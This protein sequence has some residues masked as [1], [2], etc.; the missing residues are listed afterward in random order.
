MNHKLL[1]RIATK[2]AT[3]RTN[4]SASA[5]AA[6]P[7][8]SRIVN[9]PSVINSLQRFEAIVNFTTSP[10]PVNFTGFDT[11]ANYANCQLDGFYSAAAVFPPDQ[12]YPYITLRC[13]LSPKT[14][15][16]KPLYISLNNQPGFNVPQQLNFQAPPS[17]VN[18]SAPASPD[19]NLWYPYIGYALNN[20]VAPRVPI[21]LPYTASY[22]FQYRTDPESMGGFLGALTPVGPG[23]VS[24]SIAGNTTFA[25]NFTGNDPS[26]LTFDFTASA[27]RPGCVITP[28]NV[29]FQTTRPGAIPVYVFTAQLNSGPR[30]LS[31]YVIAKNG[32]VARKY[33]LTVTTAVLAV[34][35]ALTIAASTATASVPAPTM[36][37]AFS[38]T[39][40][41]YSVT[42]DT[43]IA[44]VSF[45]A[46]PN[47]QNDQPSINWAN[48]AVDTSTT[49]QPPYPTTQTS[50]VQLQAPQGYTPP[51]MCRNVS[52]SAPQ[53]TLGVGTYNRLWYPSGATTFSGSYQYM[54]S[55]PTAFTCVGTTTFYVFVAIPNNDTVV[56]YSIRIT[57]KPATTVPAVDPAAIKVVY[58]GGGLSVSTVFSN[59]QNRVTGF[60]ITGTSIF[61]PIILTVQPTIPTYTIQV[62]PNPLVLNAL[63]SPMT[64][65][66]VLVSWD[67]VTTTTYDFYVYMRSG[68]LAGLFVG[69]WAATLGN[70][71]LKNWPFTPAFEGFTQ[72]GYVATVSD[73]SPYVILTLFP[74]SP[75]ANLTVSFMLLGCPSCI[76]V[77]ATDARYM[78]AAVQNS[79]SL[80]TPNIVPTS[81]WA[82]NRTS[83]WVLPLT[84]GSNTVQVMLYDS[85][86]RYSNSY[87]V[88]IVR[89]S[90]APADASLLQFSVLTGDGI[91]TLAAPALTAGVTSYTVTIP[92]GNINLLLNAQP[93]DPSIGAPM[94]GG[95]I[96]VT[97]NAQPVPP[98]QIP[99]SSQAP[100][101]PTADL[102]ANNLQVTSS[103][104]A[105]SWRWPCTFTRS[106]GAVNQLVA[107]VSVRSSGSAVNSYTFTL[108]WAKSIDASLT[109]LGYYDQLGSMVPLSIPSF[110]INGNQ[111][112]RACCFV[113]L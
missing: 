88:Q 99:P 111:K 7:S 103:P 24:P 106:L 11:L 84:Y 23:T 22:R 17:G 98:T 3:N 113:Y 42:V 105:Q 20:S 8:P 58:G 68:S 38:P 70:Y 59:G 109:Q 94:A 66:M 47:I 18:G 15:G 86:A 48:P 54:A 16:S 89:P 46:Q 76:T 108:K 79:N 102:M 40:Y 95:I 5:L 101:A 78:L 85:Y 29:F 36:T 55:N 51:T 81:S 73:S 63:A 25:Y 57:R 91:Q 9:I 96:S 61:Q 80:P 97:I 4:F 10:F 104:A 52:A 30:A 56:T 67:M 83:V 43:S 35:K 62:V 92:I 31:F 33:S 34:A 71:A 14:W 72:N 110:T 19:Q 65:S 53:P 69:S 50:M 75:L 1:T 41:S 21:P 12:T 32:V 82:L 87:F 93:A 107:I 44:Y 39:V 74:W 6:D 112:V 49:L 37:P 64:L 2:N 27:D 90:P 77:P 26:S 60:A 45:I 13:M 28:D 100:S